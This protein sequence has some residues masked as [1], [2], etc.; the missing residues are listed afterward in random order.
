MRSLF[1]GFA[2]WFLMGLAWGAVARVFMR[3]IT[4]SPE[5]SWAGT[6]MILAFAGLF[7][8]LIGLVVAARRAGRTRWWRLAPLPGLI[9]FAGAG[10]ILVPGAIVVAAALATRRLA[11]RVALLAIG[12]GGTYW[13]FN[14][15]DDDRFLPPRTQTLGYLL[16]VVAVA[17]LGAGLHTWWRRWTADSK[18]ATAAGEPT[19]EASPAAYGL[20]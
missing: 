3:L 17:W 14:A 15:F 1:A 7:W 11:L 20:G 13:A 18:P 10:M 16:A 6:G 19:V 5:F 2:R 8:G 4:T 9:L 12:L